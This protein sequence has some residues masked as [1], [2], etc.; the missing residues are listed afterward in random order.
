M[1]SHGS[2][3][4]A[5]P[6]LSSKAALLQVSLARTPGSAFTGTLV[7]FAVVGQIPVAALRGSPTGA[8]AGMI[9]ALMYGTGC[10]ESVTVWPARLLWRGVRGCVTDQ[11]ISTHPDTTESP[12]LLGN[13]F[14]F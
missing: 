12:K 6:L 4:T 3:G 9:F 7:V 1:K 13:I 14:P 2:G 8:G 11:A 10:I 5:Q